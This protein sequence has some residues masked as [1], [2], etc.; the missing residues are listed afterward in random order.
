MFY[1]GLLVGN[2]FSKNTYAIQPKCPPSYNI[3]TN[4]VKRKFVYE[5]ME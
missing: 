1:N 4:N 2:G 3:K 5:K